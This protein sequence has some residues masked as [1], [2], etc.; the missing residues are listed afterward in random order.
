MIISVNINDFIVWSY[1]LRKHFQIVIIIEEGEEIPLFNTY[2]KAD[3][4]DIKEELFK[5]F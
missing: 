2:A 1:R 5:V 3:L 4:E